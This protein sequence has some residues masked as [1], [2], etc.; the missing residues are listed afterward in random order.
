MAVGMIGHWP[1]MTPEQ[2]GRAV[3]RINREEEFPAGMLLHSSG[4]GDDGLRVDIWESE[5]DYRQFLQRRI[6]PAL[7]QEGYTEQGDIVF[8]P[9]HNVYLPGLE[10]L[11]RL[12]RSMLPA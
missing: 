11:S 2:Y 6:L 3:E 9:V 12:G 5:K 4:F 10:E 8:F 1:G 7:R